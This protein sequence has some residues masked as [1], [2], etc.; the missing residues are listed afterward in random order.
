MPPPLLLFSS[1][2]V[3]HHVISWCSCTDLLCEFSLAPQF[4]VAPCI[5]QWSLQ[6]GAAHCRNHTK[7]SDAHQR[8]THRQLFDMQAWVTRSCS[9]S[10]SQ[11][12]N[13][14]KCKQQRDATAHFS[15]LTLVLSLNDALLLFRPT[16]KTPRG[17][18]Q[19]RASRFFC[20][21]SSRENRCRKRCLSL[22]M[23]GNST[24]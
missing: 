4:Y 13:A 23:R 21:S 24:L 18:L 6:C 17:P 15:F 7:C 2:L 14:V 19:W 10:F 9:D 5:T 8:L 22:S 16:R 20:R 12:P 11:T 1:F 3:G